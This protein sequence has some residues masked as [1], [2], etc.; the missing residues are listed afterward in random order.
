[1][2]VYY[3]NGSMVTKI[4]YFISFDKFR[5]LLDYKKGKKY[6]VL[7][8]KNKPNVIFAWVLRGLCHF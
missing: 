8:R 3:K 2:V 5:T 4:A 6:A 1:M 7:G